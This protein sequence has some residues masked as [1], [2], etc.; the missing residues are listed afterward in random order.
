MRFPRDLRRQLFEE[1]VQEIEYRASVRG[2]KTSRDAFVGS[3]RDLF[4]LVRAK[5]GGNHRISDG[6]LEEDMYSLGIRYP[7]LGD[8]APDTLR[9]LFPEHFK[10]Q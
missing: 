3:K 10:T 7:S 9:S 4:V 2:I 5:L 8:R 1:V 6:A